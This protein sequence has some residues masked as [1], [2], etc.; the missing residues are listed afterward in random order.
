MKVSRLMLNWILQFALKTT[1]RLQKGET[2]GHE[3][4]PG[5]NQT[6]LTSLKS[7]DV[8]TQSINQSNFYSA[9][10]AGESAFNSKLE[11]TVSQHQ[12]SIGLAGVYGAKA[13]SKRCVLRC[14]FPSI[15]QSC[16]Y[17][18]NISSEA[19]L[20]DATAEIVSNDKIPRAG[21]DTSRPNQRYVFS[22]IS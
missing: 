1:E 10:I 3:R 6:I 11:E 4:F 15:N 12:L 22:D 2:K 19:R 9:N 21:R 13:M 14:F 20:S 18:T 8:L 7:L 5:Y 17:I 16:F